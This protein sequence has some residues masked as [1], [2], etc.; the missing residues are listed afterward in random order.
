MKTLGIIGGLGPETTS[1]F[2][3][4]LVFGCKKINKSCYPNLIIDSIPLPFNIEKD[5][6][7]KGISQNKCLPYLIYSAERLEKAGADFLVMPCNSLHIYIDKIRNAVGI[8]V[9]SILEET[10]DYLA[11]LGVN[12]VGILGTSLTI[13][14]KLYS[15]VLNN[16]KIKILTPNSENQV[17]MGK[18]IHN[19]VSQSSSKKDR[20]SLIRII[21]D[22]KGV[23]NIILACTDLQILSPKIRGIKIHDTMKI[24]ANSAV[25][26]INK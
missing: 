24:L 10:G 21:K 17:R 22:I 20:D 3:M 19:L 13:K 16:K 1:R 4:E 15:G 25:R 18:I 8:P 12:K 11:S 14:S 2:Y 6:I 9:L 23:N 26:E 5:A 7:T